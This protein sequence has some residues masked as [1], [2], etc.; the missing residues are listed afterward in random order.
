MGERVGIVLTPVPRRFYD[1]PVL[2]VA[3]DLLGAM[4][5]SAIGGGLVRIR[6]TE[7]EAYGGVADP[8]SHAYRGPS[9]R[10]RTMFGPPGHAYVYFTYGMHFCMNLVTGAPGT[11]SAVLLRAGTVV[12]GQDVVARRRPG[13]RPREYARGPA[14]LTRALGVDRTVDGADVCAD[15]P[16]K[17]LPNGQVASGAVRSGP[18][19]G[20]TVATDVPWRFWLAGEDSVSVYRAGGPRRRRGS[21]RV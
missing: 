8:A 20:V 3:R 16:L 18:R 12:E 1:R 13:A 7:V 10:N 9:L 19:V 4:I 14:R 11:A 15:G 21:T 17:V 2:E 5:E 6:L